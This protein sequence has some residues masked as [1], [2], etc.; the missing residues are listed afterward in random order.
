MNLSRRDFLASSALGLLA[1]GF[2]GAL[3]G[4]LRRVGPLVEL[5]RDTGFYTGRGGTIGWLANDAGSVV[6]DS[7]YAQT[8]SEFAA[9]FEPRG[10]AQYEALLNT[11][12]H[13]DHTGGNG[14][15][16]G[17]A[18]RIVA[19]ERVPELQR[20]A[21]AASEGGAAQTYADTTFTREWRLA[22]GDETVRAKHYGPAH[23]GGDSIV[24]FERAAVVHMGDLVF[25]RAYPFV[26]RQGGAS[27]EGWV[28]VLEA[29]T[30]EHTAET[31]YIFGHARPGFEVTGRR[32][33][34]LVQRDFLS[35]VLDTTRRAVAAGKPR[36]E[37]AA[38][39]TLPGFPDHA[40]L[41]QRL[42]LSAV[43]GVAWDEL[44]GA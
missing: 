6:V 18:R 31:I 40:A 20:Q 12:H 34:V 22:V 37:A 36:A 44:T 43:L 17:S 21:A 29:V 13:A 25:N 38:L 35:A 28:R 26:D 16:G 3:R 23:T 24:V 41:A 19:H 8:A 4:A 33:D 5:R 30:S 14:V 32:G 7:Q 10:G 11:H 27:I 1:S 42:T 2:P 39:E 15:L 9:A